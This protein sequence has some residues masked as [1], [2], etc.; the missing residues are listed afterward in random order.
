[1]CVRERAR[2]RESV[3]QRERKRDCVFERQTE[4]DFHDDEA[5]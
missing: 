1:M 3:R 5:D 4:T 2:V